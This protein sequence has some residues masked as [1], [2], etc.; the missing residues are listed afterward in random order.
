[1]KQAIEMDE[2]STLQGLE[3]FWNASDGCSEYRVGAWAIL[4][5]LV[6]VGGSWDLLMVVK[7]APSSL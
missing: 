4:Y 6:K 5:P 7:K 2:K 3:G 1:M